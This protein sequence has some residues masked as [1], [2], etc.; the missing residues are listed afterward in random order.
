VTSLST[1][2]NVSSP[3]TAPIISSRFST[4]LPILL[5]FLVFALFIPISAFAQSETITVS[6]TVAS[7]TDSSG[8]FGTAGANLAG[9]TFSLVYTFNL[10][11]IYQ[12]A[13]CSSSACASENAG[14]SSASPGTAALTVGGG[15]PYY[16][17]TNGSDTSRSSLVYQTVP[18]PESTYS[19]GIGVTDS[20]GEDSVN[21]AIGGSGTAPINWAWRTALSGVLSG[22][23]S[24]SASF[25][26]SGSGLANGTL[27]MSSIS[28]SG[29]PTC[30]ATPTI[31][32]DTSSVGGQPNI[33]NKNDSTNIDVDIS[34]ATTWFPVTFS[35]SGGGTYTTSATQ[36]ITATDLSGAGSVYYQSNGSTAVDQ[37]TATACGNTSASVNLYDYQVYLDSGDTTPYNIHTSQV[38]DANYT[39]YAALTG[40]QVQTF[41]EN[42][43][44]GYPSFLASFYFVNP[45]IPGDS[46]VESGFIDLHGTLQYAS[47]DPIYCSDGSTTCLSVG[48][49]ATASAAAA[50]WLDAYFNGIN[51]ELL[52]TKLQ[53]ESSLNTKSSLPSVST[54]NNALGCS[55]A[56]TFNEQLYCSGTTFYNNYH[57]DPAE[58]TFFPVVSYNWEDIQYA[59]ESG[60]TCE[61]VDSHSGDGDYNELVDGCDVVGLSIA[62]AATYAQYKFTPFVQTSTS[63]GGVRLFEQNWYNYSSASWYQ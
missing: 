26:I 53:V 36:T 47:D 14:S 24:K 21:I 12:T 38:T 43:N 2:F 45:L 9:D 17:G 29:A 11:N 59:Y 37:P 4:G 13:G 55:G 51:P 48:T 8:V 33:L 10:A 60:V 49:Y 34:G 57:A 22:A 23:T 20:S 19:T 52:L 50:I 6:G 63:G 35:Y 15:G 28:E 32:I 54:L 7:G 30:S 27:T 46:G 1:R 58:P 25:N 16:F 62:T 5:L 18:L 31:D 41:V 3:P 61:D 56:S 42:S 40:D 39:N 44:G